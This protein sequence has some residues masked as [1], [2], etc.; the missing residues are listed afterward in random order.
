MFLTEGSVYICAIAV[1]LCCILR[2]F[3]VAV[4]RLVVSCRLQGGG[5]VFLCSR[6]GVRR[7]TA[8]VQ[9]SSQRRGM[10]LWALSKKMQQYLKYVSQTSGKKK[11]KRSSTSL[12]AWQKSW[13]FLSLIRIRLICSKSSSFFCVIISSFP[14]CFRLTFLV[15]SRL[16]DITQRWSFKALMMRKLS[17][18]ADPSTQVEK[19]NKAL[20]DCDP[21]VVKN[22]TS[23]RC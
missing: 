23:P 11:K 5:K 8:R 17:E 19:K 12:K 7:L 14:L 18:K 2:L 9:V 22:T 15:C 1:L 16:L 4:A 21:S 13:S 3:H 10:K 6:A 20:Y